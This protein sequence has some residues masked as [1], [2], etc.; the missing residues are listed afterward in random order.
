MNRELKRGLSARH[1]RFIA[2][3]SAIGT[4]LF[5]GSAEAIQKAGPSVLIAYLIGG[6]IIYLVLRA[7]GE[8]SVRRPVAGSFGDFATENIG[9]LAGFLTGWTFIFEM[10]VVCLADVTAFGVYMGF[11]F[12]DVPRWVWVLAVVFFIGAVNLF[13]VKVFGEMEF[14]F[15]LV[16][17]TAI[18]AMIAGGT[19]ILIWGFGAHDADSGIT[20]LWATDGGFMPNGIGGLLASFAV[21]MFAFGGSEIIGITAGE[22]EDPS[23]TIPQAVNTVPVRILL[24]YVCSLFVIMAIIPWNQI[25]GDSS[26]FVQIFESLGVGPAA[27]VLNI[28]V[29][30]AALSAIN[31]DVFGAGRMMYGL[32]LQG[33]APAVLRRVSRNGVPWFT[34]AIMVVALLIAVVLNAVIPE[35]VFLI[36]ASIA[37]FATIFVWGMILLS[38][39]RSR[40][41]MSAQEQ[42]ELTFGVPFWPYGQQLAMAFLAF[43]AL[44]V[45]WDPDTRVAFAVGA[46]WLLLLVVAYY[47]FVVRGTSAA[48]QR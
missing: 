42:R 40:R 32:A 20:N 33:Q 27:T 44:L 4:G 14:W 6:A 15:T 45:A 23:T 10:I 31:S 25:S 47:W 16:K 30:T 36:I 28:V 12:P 29:I 37:T 18:I 48:R 22:A 2:L 3:G 7:L 46:G 8:L 41:A 5:Y 26:P 21:V 43:V 39:Y 19:A 1:I 11:W 13:S 34:V 35:S 38:Q 17:V 24:F 9:P